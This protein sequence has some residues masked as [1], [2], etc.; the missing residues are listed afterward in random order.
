MIHDLCEKNSV[1]FM[2]VFHPYPMVLKEKNEF[3]KIRE[4]GFDT[5]VSYAGKNLDRALFEFTKKQGI[6][7]LSLGPFVIKKEA[8][9]FS[10]GRRGTEIFAPDNLHFTPYGHEL[11]ANPMV[12]FLTKN[13]PGKLSGKAN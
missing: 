12:N 1:P 8:E 6:P 11:I 10:A 7:Y 9:L 3:T 5:K 4:F 13:L 2:I